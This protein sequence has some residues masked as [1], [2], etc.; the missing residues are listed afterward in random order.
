VSIIKSPI[1]ST[2]RVLF[3][4]RLKTQVKRNNELLR[5]YFALVNYSVASTATARRICT[6]VGCD[7]EGK[8]RLKIAI[9]KDGNR[10]G[11]SLRRHKECAS[12]LRTFAPARNGPD[13]K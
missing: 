12:A 8:T 3:A 13:I 4:F 1:Q 10:P 5:L 9:P 7:T 2:G 6:S 11:R